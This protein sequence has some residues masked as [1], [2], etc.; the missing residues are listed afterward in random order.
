MTLMAASLLLSDYGKGTLSEVGIRKILDICNKGGKPVLVDPAR[1]RDVVSYKGCTVLKPN[2]AEAALATGIEI[3]DRVSLETAA[4]RLL[5]ASRAKY[6]VITQGSDG[7]TIFK[8]SAVPVHIAGLSRP[9]YDITGAGDTILSVLGYVLAGKGTIEEAAEI[10]NVAGSIVVGKLGAA[11]VTRQEIIREL[12]S[13]QHV[14]SHKVKTHGEISAIC[15]EHRLRKERVVFTN[16]CFDLL[17]AGHIKLFQFA[18]NNGEILIVGLN[19]DASVRKLKGP[20][21][22]VLKQTD[23]AYILSALEQVDY[24]VVFEEPTPLRLI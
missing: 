19:S 9:V 10:A 16:G 20:G 17:H 8:N 24:I 18:K 2:R 12:L 13:F 3:V 6:V 14:A 11:P 22:P 21:R 1:R 15:K 23:R 5:E 4:K 7:M